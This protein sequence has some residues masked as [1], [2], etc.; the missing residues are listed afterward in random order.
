MLSARPKAEADNTYDT[1]IIPDITKTEYCFIIHCFEIN[2]DKYTVAR[3]RFD[4]ALGNH[5]S[6]A[7]YRLVSYLLADN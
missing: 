6:R 7:T 4:I 3:N 5:A 2:N 1:S